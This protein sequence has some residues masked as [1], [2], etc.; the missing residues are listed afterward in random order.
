MLAYFNLWIKHR[1]CPQI[2]H[3]TLSMLS[4]KLPMASL[5]SSLT[6]MMPSQEAHCQAPWET[7]KIQEQIIQ[8]K[9]F[10][11]LPTFCATYLPFSWHLVLLF[12]AVYDLEQEVAEE[13]QQRMSWVRKHGMVQGFLLAPQQPRSFI[14]SSQFCSQGSASPLLWVFCSPCQPRDPWP[15]LWN[16]K[17]VL[18]FKLSARIAEIEERGSH[19]W[20]QEKKICHS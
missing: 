14:S 10:S 18:R 17:A 2:R 20:M 4:S 6:H 1:G 15:C 5:N 12:R 13:Q 7:F 8:E 16:I 3:P 9:L 19:I 11:L